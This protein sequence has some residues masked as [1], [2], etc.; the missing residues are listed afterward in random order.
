MTSPAARHSGAHERRPLHAVITG[1]TGGLGRAIAARLG[2][3]GVAL[4]LLARDAAQLEQL[5]HGLRRRASGAIET[6]TCELAN[7]DALASAARS[8]LDRR[9][10]PDV[11][12][13]N[14]AVQGPIGRFDAVDW[15]AWRRTIEVD[16]LAPARLCQLLAPAMVESG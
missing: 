1:A 4:T 5:A 3:D 14:A 2:A 11:L 13:N 9:R 15:Q 12:V 8:L 7:A 6:L 10:L 16:L